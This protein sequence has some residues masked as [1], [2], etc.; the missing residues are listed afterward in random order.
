MMLFTCEYVSGS[1]LWV[2]RPIPHFL[3]PPNGAPAGFLHMN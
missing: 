1:I 2:S 3:L